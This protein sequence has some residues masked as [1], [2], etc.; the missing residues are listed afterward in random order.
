M[1]CG[2]H[3]HHLHFTVSLTGVNVAPISNKELDQLAS[4]WGWK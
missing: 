3:L 4:R 1:E 2:D